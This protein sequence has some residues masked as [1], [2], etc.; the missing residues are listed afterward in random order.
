MNRASWIGRVLLALWI[1]GICTPS[2]GAGGFTTIRFPSEDGLEITA[3]LYRA[4]E[5]KGP[6][7]ILYH[8]AGW[9][10]GEYR[11]IAPR[12]V[13]LGYNC[14]AVDQRSGYAINGVVNET[15][16]RAA[17]AGKP[18][19]F[20][21]AY[22]DMEAA[23]EYARKKLG[24]K[25]IVLWGSSYSAS[26]VLLLA[27][28]HPDEVR[29]V[30]AFS[31]GEYFAKFGKSP[32]LIRDGVRGLRTP[33][34]ITSAKG[35]AERWRSI[36]EAIPAGAKESFLPARAAGAHGSQALWRSTP[37]SGEYWQ[38]VVGFLRRHAPP[39]STGER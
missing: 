10:R 24:A 35:E 28:H 34:L 2:A 6:F 18:M 39:P 12:L 15:A 11:E 9:S 14:L 20:L 21:A 19:D 7:I 8:R 29:A 23:L 36:F 27:A 17:R 5:S 25:E 32:H 38:A 31:P 26:L 1:F 16:M 13:E 30:L 4:Q 22:Q 37:G 3:D 33:C